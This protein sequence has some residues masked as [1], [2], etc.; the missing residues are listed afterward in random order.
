MNENRICP[1]REAR[2]ELRLALV[3]HSSRLGALHE[4]LVPGPLAVLSRKHSRYL[5]Y[6]YG[7]GPGG[8]W[9]RRRAS[10]RAVG[11]MLHGLGSAYSRSVPRACATSFVTAWNPS[12]G[13]PTAGPLTRQIALPAQ[14]SHVNP[15]SRVAGYTRA[16]AARPRPRQY[17]HRSRWR[18][19]VGKGRLYRRA[20]NG[21]NRRSG[22]SFT[23]RGLDRLRLRLRGLWGSHR[24]K[25]VVHEVDSYIARQRARGCRL[26]PGYRS[27]AQQTH[28]SQVH[29]YRNYNCV[30]KRSVFHL[31]LSAHRFGLGRNCQG[32]GTRAFCLVG[33]LDALLPRLRLVAVYHDDSARVLL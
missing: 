29:E 11:S 7:Y 12:H 17:S 20:P 2:S 5:A 30:R 18:D 16:G 23:N 33:K 4:C 25:R 15:P 19:W 10:V 32:A 27:K 9:R 1:V 31:L 22:N 24:R 8:G 14:R 13:S 3:A 26:E 6:P 28:R 21:C